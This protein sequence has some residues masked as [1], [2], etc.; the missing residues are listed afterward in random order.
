MGDF[1][2]A[3]LAP[4]LAAIG[5]LIAAILTP[6]FELVA[7]ILGAILHFILALVANLLGASFLMLHATGIKRFAYGLMALTSLHL[8][9]GLFLPITNTAPTLMLSWFFSGPVLLASLGLL[10][11]SA[12][13]PAAVTFT[14]P[15]AEKP[16]PQARPKAPPEVPM[17]QLQT[18]SISAAKELVTQGMAVVFGLVVLFGVLS[19]TSAQTERKSLRARLCDS[20]LQKYEDSV[21]PS[22]RARAQKALDFGEEKLGDRLISKYPCPKSD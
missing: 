2:G 19:L 15:E 6:L 9:L 8:L 22:W 17:S 21:S 7:I 16:A 12:L 3:I 11:V 10:V 5:S 14:Q 4:V 18:S 1:I 13:L 20:A